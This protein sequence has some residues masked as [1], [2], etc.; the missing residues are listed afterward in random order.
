MQWEQ[1]PSKFRENGLGV[2]SALIPAGIQHLWDTLCWSHTQP[3]PWAQPPRTEHSEPCP[4]SQVAAPRARERI[5]KIRGE[6]CCFMCRNTLWL[7][8]SVWCT[9]QSSKGE[10]QAPLQGDVCRIDFFLLRKIKAHVTR[11]INLYQSQKKL[12]NSFSLT[13]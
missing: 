10:L 4:P 13:K 9:S 7:P 3:P 12:Q 6:K 1:T 11:L 5:I 8:P 2:P